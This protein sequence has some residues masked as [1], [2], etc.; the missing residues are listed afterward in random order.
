[1]SMVSNPDLVSERKLIYYTDF[2]F[3]FD[4]GQH[5]GVSEGVIGNDGH[6]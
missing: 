3:I 2:C 4:A 1:M 5:S 6:T